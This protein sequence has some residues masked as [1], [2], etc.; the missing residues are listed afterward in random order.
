MEAIGGWCT[1]DS[2]RERAGCVIF[3]YFSVRPTPRFGVYLDKYRSNNS[4]HVDGLELI[5][6]LVNAIYYSGSINTYVS[7]YSI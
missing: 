6:V 4:D 2:S 3:R 7:S 5:D 1:A